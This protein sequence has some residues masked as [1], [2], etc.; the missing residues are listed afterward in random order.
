MRCKLPM[1][2]FRSALTAASTPGSERSRGPFT[3]VNSGVRRCSARNRRTRRRRRRATS[4]FQGVSLSIRSFTTLDVARFVMGDVERVTALGRVL[5][6]PYM[7]AHGDVDTSIVTLE[8]VSGAIGV[9]QNSRRTVHGYDPARR[10]S[11]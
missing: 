6:A 1:F 8:F 3:P 4:R 2:R 11:R 5:V 10:G 9:V 7:A